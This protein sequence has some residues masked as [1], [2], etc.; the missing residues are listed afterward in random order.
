VDRIGWLSRPA[1]KAA[2]GQTS[3]RS[4]PTGRT[5][6]DGLRGRTLY[7]TRHAELNWNCLTPTQLSRIRSCFWRGAAFQLHL[8][9]ADRHI[10][11]RPFRLDFLE[12]AAAPRAADLHWRQLLTNEGTAPSSPSQ[13]DLV[14][15]NVGRLRGRQRQPCNHWD[16]ARG[17]GVLQG[18]LCSAS[19]TT[20]GYVPGQPGTPALLAE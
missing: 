11:R 6:L 18:N 1:A 8:A 13:F 4:V 12:H 16:V 7:D 15:Y 19:R 20:D 17:F 14:I 2:G 10:G 5:G 3:G 9:G